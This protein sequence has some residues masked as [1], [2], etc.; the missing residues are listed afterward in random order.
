MDAIFHPG[1]RYWLPATVLKVLGLVDLLRGVLHT[2]FVDRVAKVF[3]RLDLSTARQDQLT[4]LGAFGISNL[5]TGTLFLLVSVE[6]PQ[7]AA[8]V[9]LAVPCAYAL[10]MAGIRTAGVRREAAFLGRYFMIVYLG[11][12]V[13]T[14]LVSRFQP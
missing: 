11:V 8:W 10:G 14:F 7:L 6:A 1:V 13:I 5:L 4:L 2:F 3:A 12:C 9:L